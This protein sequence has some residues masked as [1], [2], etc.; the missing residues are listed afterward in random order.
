MKRVINLKI[1]V[2][3]KKIKIIKRVLSLSVLDDFIIN[4]ESIISINESTIIILL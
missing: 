3:I 2:N 1:D 4:F